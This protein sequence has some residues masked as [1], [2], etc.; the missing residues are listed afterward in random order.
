MRLIFMTNI[1][2]FVCND[3]NNYMNFCYDIFNEISLNIQQVALKL[4]I[5]C[6]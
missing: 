2:I 4:D 3:M 1:V 5:V 6:E